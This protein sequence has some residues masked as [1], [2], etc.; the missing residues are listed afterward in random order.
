MKLPFMTIDKK[1][2]ASVITLLVL[3]GVTILTLHTIINSRMNRTSADN[4]RHRI[5]SFYAADGM[6]TLLA[7]EMIDSNENN[8]LK[9][10]FLIKNVG[11]FSTGRHGYNP[12]A[13]VDT[14]IGAGTTLTSTND[15]CTFLYQKYVGDVDISVKVQYMSIVLNDPFCGIMIRK[16]LNSNS[17]DAAVTWPYRSNNPVS[18]KV[19][20][21]DG[22][23]VVDITT[24]PSGYGS[25][26][27][28]K[29]SGTI[30]TSFRSD[31]GSTWTIVG[32]DTISMGDTVY[33]GLFV[34][35]GSQI[36]I[37]KGVFSDLRG[38][39]RRS[40]TDSL[41]FTT[42]ENT[43]VKYTIN[44]ILP[45][46]FSMTTEAFK[47]KNNGEK[48]FVTKL[49]QA[50]ARKRE[51]GFIATAID[52]I[53]LPV[54]FYEYRANLTNPEFNTAAS[55]V[56]IKKM[57]QNSLDADRKPVPPFFAW[58]EQPRFCFMDCFD[59]NFKSWYKLSPSER[60][61]KLNN[62]DIE[63]EKNCNKIHGSKSSKGW[64]F[65]D[66]LKKWFRP[67]D[68]PG[69]EFDPYT[70][71][72]TN[73]KN[74]P[75][76]GGGSVAN[77]WV[78]KNY[79]STKSFANIVIYDSLKFRELP[80]GSGTFVFGDPYYSLNIDTQYFVLPC[81]AWWVGS[82]YKFMP[83]KMRGFKFDP[84]NYTS[85]SPFCS[86]VENFGFSMEMHKMFT[87]KHG[88]NFSF[89]GDDDVWVFIN[90]RFVIDLGGIHPATTS[91]V[92]LDTLG[93]IEGNQ[94]W[95][96][97]FYSERCPTE[98][99]IYITTNMQLFVPPQSNKR[100]W[101]RDYGDLN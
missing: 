101:T 78:G 90:N 18:M 57:I 53:Y 10:A 22:S 97:L 55:M 94:Y 21:D 37:S 38:M 24:T 77:E 56:V 3:F 31:N 87:Y 19:R 66:S 42:V 34:G 54:T 11:L 63:S 79:D 5:Q 61:A 76:P 23:G 82:K 93:L 30:F 36:D 86:Q 100:I 75:I 62:L 65:S 71:T 59:T 15:K 96:D 92:D 91:S 1:G 60:S 89:T 35:S 88:Q 99:N 28:L 6:I 52:S 2:I 47:K 48:I 72:W 9:D 41:T 4:Y 74:R 14:L 32:K 29:R 39:I 27:R 84:A 13:N 98:S 49:D 20:S 8:Y 12:Y 16:T 51:S 81:N 80:S 95:F 70:G 17:M 69:A 44:E 85:P 73:L 26:I 7:Q 33:A 46:Q 68:A 40:Y 45:D 25:W 64:W 67:S 50:L 43:T 58:N 83:L